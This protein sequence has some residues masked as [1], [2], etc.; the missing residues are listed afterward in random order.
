M[1]NVTSILT[2]NCNRE[3]TSSITKSSLWLNRLFINL[4]HDKKNTCLTTDCGDINPN[5]PS[6]YRT[7]ANNPAEQLCYFSIRSNDEIYNTIPARRIINKSELKIFIHFKID[8]VVGKAE[9]GQKYS[10]NADKEGDYVLKF[11]NDS[12]SDKEYGDGIRTRFFLRN[13]PQLRR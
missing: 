5:D 9:S 1:N 13:R 7:K 8:R 11:S 4:I 2:N 6:K 10:Y 12:T 3:T